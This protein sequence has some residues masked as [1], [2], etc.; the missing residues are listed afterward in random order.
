MN[1]CGREFSLTEK[2]ARRG[3]GVVAQLVGAACAGLV[4]AAAAPALAAGYPSLAEVPPLPKD[5]RTDGAWRS[6]VVETRV[7]GARLARAA[8]KEPW[9]LGD[10]VGWAAR[11]RNEASPPPPI[12]TPS[13]A[14]TDALVKAMQARASGPSRRR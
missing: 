7:T 14:D 1:G 6:A 2:R 13:G 10:T 5:V 9:T 12:T 11:E 4:A 3:A 8:A